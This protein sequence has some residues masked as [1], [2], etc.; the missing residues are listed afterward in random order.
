MKQPTASPPHV[1][2][3]ALFGEFL[4]VS[5]LASG[6]GIIWAH[7]IA[8]DQR[9]WLSDAEFTD[10]VSICQFMPGPN[11]IGIAV[12]AGAKLRG[13]IGAVAATAGFVVIPGFVG[14]SLGVLWFSHTGVP[15][16]R[17]ALIGIAAAAAGM[18]IATGLRLLKAYRGRLPALLFAGLAFAGI[19]ICQFPLLLVLLALAPLSIATAAIAGGRA[20]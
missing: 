16:L 17:N 8:V 13:L 20:R 3:S 9:R 4:K 2:L 11:V 14:F 1:T 5:L 19:A 12:C 10:I 7:R 15:L 6:G 18:M